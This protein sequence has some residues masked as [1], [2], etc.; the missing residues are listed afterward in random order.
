M[1]HVTILVCSISFGH[2]FHSSSLMFARCYRQSRLCRFTSA[3]I[4]WDSK[5]WCRKLITMIDL[6]WWLLVDSSLNQKCQRL[7]LSNTTCRNCLATLKKLPHFLKVLL[8][9]ESWITLSKRKIPER[10]MCQEQSRSMKKI[11]KISHESDSNGAAFLGTGLSSENYPSCIHNHSSMH[12]FMTWQLCG[13]K[14]LVALETDQIYG[15]PSLE[16]FSQVVRWFRNSWLA[17]QGSSTSM[18]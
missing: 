11:S 12:V 8:F 16:F 18:S 2:I 4:L 1:L 10:R 7:L 17:T 3:Y 6:T 15:T 14:D 5:N 13:A 9:I